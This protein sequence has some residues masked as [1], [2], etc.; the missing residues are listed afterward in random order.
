MTARRLKRHDPL[1]A[2][3]T[4]A[5]M[6]AVFA[7][8]IHSLTDFNLHIPANAIATVTVLAVTLNAGRVMPSG[9]SSNGLPEP[10]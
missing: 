7:M 2:Y 10:R 5:G 1:A 3:L 9:R 4:L 8:L 6:T